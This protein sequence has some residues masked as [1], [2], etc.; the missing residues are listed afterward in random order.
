MTI[1]KYETEKEIPAAT[2]NTKAVESGISERN[3]ATRADMAKAKIKEIPLEV[4]S[5]FYPKSNLYP[6][7]FT[8]EI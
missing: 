8:V 7:P 6:T 4:V 5:I 3:A 2:N 1:S